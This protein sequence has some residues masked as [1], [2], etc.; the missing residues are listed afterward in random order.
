[1]DVAQPISS[2]IP[3]LDGPVLGALSG[4]TQPLTLSRVHAL[5]GRGSLAGVRRVLLR[6]VDTGIVDQV[7]GGYVLNREHVAAPAIGALAGLDGELAERLRRAVGR[8]DGD[9]ELLGLFGSAARRDGDAHSDIDV[10]L[11]SS[12]DDA[13]EFAG[14]LASRIQRW[15]GNAAQVITVAPEELAR[16][17][18]DGE[19]IVDRWERDLV[20]LHGD[21]ALLGAAA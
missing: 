1:M 3:S 15:T 19:P 4:T 6:L 18:R 17:R 16:M 11:V 7:T 13:R 14:S 2:V 8:W 21:R 5:A 12:A 10:L 9:C 20:V